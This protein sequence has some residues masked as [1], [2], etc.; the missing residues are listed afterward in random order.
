[1][2]SNTLNRLDSLD[3]PST[4]SSTAHS[5]L[6]V[7]LEVSNSS[8]TSPNLSRKTSLL[9][10]N[11]DTT[12]SRSSSAKSR[13]S[14]CSF[15]AKTASDLQK[16]GKTSQAKPSTKS[17]SFR[18]QP[19]KNK[20]IEEKPSPAPSLER[21]NTEKQS[22]L[23]KKP[24]TLQKSIRLVKKK[25]LRRG[26]SATSAD[27]ACSVA[28]PGKIQKKNSFYKVMDKLRGI[29]RRSSMVS[30]ESGGQT[31]FLESISRMSDSRIVENW[32]LS[33]DDDQQNPEPI[34]GPSSIDPPDSLDPPESLDQPALENSTDSLMPPKS[35]TEEL[36]TPTNE[37]FEPDTKAGSSEK[38]K[39]VFDISSEDLDD[40]LDESEDKFTRR[41]S[42]FGRAFGRQISESSEYTTG[43]NDTG[44]TAHVTAINTLR[45]TSYLFTSEG[46]EMRKVNL[47]P[48]SPTSAIFK[49]IIPPECPDP[50][51]ED[52]EVEAINSDR[53][54][55]HQTSKSNET[56]KTMSSAAIPCS[57]KPSEA[58]HEG[59]DVQGT[60]TRNTES[61][62][63]K[64][65]SESQVIPA[66]I[67]ESVGLCLLLI[68]ILLSIRNKLITNTS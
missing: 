24:S 57:Y 50:E 48:P 23:S 67:S 51:T 66:L 36:V 43:T 61:S 17:S 4:C 10:A 58:E 46:D 7:E 29:S 47:S 30:G 27:D 9:D 39:I 44:E 55:S 68:M 54:D 31:E 63:T 41:C 33:L 11:I 1:M 34:D 20:K 12:I 25:S 19:V 65:Q 37:H 8:K 52:L 26:D 22:K 60:L 49:L 15:S 21:S 5:D 59:S 13:T 18:K 16:S 40:D 3:K 62:D 45:N 38:H 14:S 2:N 42:R 56:V 32:L 53:T 28:S 35:R 64:R 6:T